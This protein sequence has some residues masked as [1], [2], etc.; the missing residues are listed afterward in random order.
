MSG[1]LYEPI[2]MFQSSSELKLR[3]AEWPP[4]L[5]RGAANDNIAGWSSPVA[6]QAH[7]L[8]VVGSNPTP[9]TN[10]SLNINHLES[11]RSLDQGLSVFLGLTRR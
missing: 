7:N 10:R 11:P 9:A 8:K 5:M 2:P 4:E 1:I 6:R 3:K